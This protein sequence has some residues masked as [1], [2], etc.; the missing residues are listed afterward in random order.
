MIDKGN[1][2]HA[3][4]R[5]HSADGAATLA[6]RGAWRRAAASGCATAAPPRADLPRRARALL[7]AEGRESN[8]M[9]GG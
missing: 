2:A 1:Y 6:T 4:A 3:A 9:V 5:T 8:K 7:S